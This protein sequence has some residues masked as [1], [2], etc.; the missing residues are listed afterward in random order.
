MN[1]LER[2]NRIAEMM[3]WK[4]RK[5]THGNCCTCQ[6]C[7][8]DHESCNDC[9]CEF[10][11]YEDAALQA[12]E[13]I[14]RKLKARVEISKEYDS[15]GYGWDCTIYFEDDIGCHVVCHVN[16]VMATAIA[17]AVAEAWS[18]AQNMHGDEDGNSRN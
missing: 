4:F 16:E 3:G 13:T 5:P 14:G 18:I 10:G 17:D 12:L 8:R 6:R 1:V 9:P 7:G 11:E 2:D 15:E